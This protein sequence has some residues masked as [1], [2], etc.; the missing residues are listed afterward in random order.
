M[1]SE[2]EAVITVEKKHL[3]II[4][5]AIIVII[6]VTMVPIIP[7]S[8]QTVYQVTKPVPNSPIIQRNYI[9]N[10]QLTKIT[11]S[12]QTIEIPYDQNI[13]ITWTS[14]T[15]MNLVALLSTAATE[16]F[17]QTTISE[18][19]IPIGPTLFTGKELTPIITNLIQEKLPQLIQKTAQTNYQKTN[20]NKDTTQRYVKTGTYNL[21]L[22]SIDKTGELNIQITYN[23]S[24]TITE[25]IT[26]TD[27]KMITI[28]DYLLNNT[29][30]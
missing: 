24:E 23:T 1:S 26:R 10:V 16:N 22:L 28:I 6:F 5:A 30:K 3:L 17:I 13:N 4:A 8:A 12:M 25:T 2:N 9:Q 19:G 27:T 11:F 18:I 15:S 29:K 20:T 21:L 7:I 14:T